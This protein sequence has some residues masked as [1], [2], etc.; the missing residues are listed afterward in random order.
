MGQWDDSRALFDYCFDNFQILN[1]ADNE[2]RL[3][4][5]D[6]DTGDFNTNE[7][8]VN[9]DT[10]GAIVIPKT[11]TFTDAVPTVDDSNASG[12]VAGRISYTYA[13]RVV[14]GA[15]IV[16][17]GRDRGAVRVWKCRCTDRYRAGDRDAYRY[18][19]DEG[20]DISDQFPCD[21][22]HPSWHCGGSGSRAAC[23]LC[24]LQIPD[25]EKKG[26]HRQK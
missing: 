25:L 18:G 2:T 16:K 10:N 20:K 21:L 1:I 11:A 13:D 6:V 4:G 17:T 19:A 9:I 3:S 15:D 8:F 5:G 14:G 12:N 24:V 26:F 22:T 23:T 7:K